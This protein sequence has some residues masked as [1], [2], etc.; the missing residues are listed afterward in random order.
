MSLTFRVDADFIGCQFFCFGDSTCASLV[1][2]E[3]NKEEKM[4]T[5]SPAEEKKG[6][7]Q[8]SKM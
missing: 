5:S 6:T 7:L 3:E 2:A 8:I 4:D 1:I